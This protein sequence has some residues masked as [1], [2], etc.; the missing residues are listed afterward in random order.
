M[1]FQLTWTP[2][3]QYLELFEY[4]PALAGQSITVCV[5]PPQ[6]VMDERAKIQGEFSKRFDA[7][8]KALTDKD[9][10]AIAEFTAWTKDV[11][12]PGVNSWY[13]RLFSHGEEKYTAEDITQYSSVDV[14]FYNWLLRRAIEMIDE[15][16]SGR[17]KNFA[18]R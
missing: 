7:Y 14:H 5:N 18:S 6:E 9:D 17:K 16:R 3:I 2:V 1:P 15:H 13:A 11:F 12:V 8:T 10:A 4:A